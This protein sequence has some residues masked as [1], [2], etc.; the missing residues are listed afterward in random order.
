MRVS[1]VALVATLVLSFLGT[2]TAC[3]LVPSQASCDFRPT[4]ALC[5]DLLTNRNGQL[6]PTLVTLCVGAYSDALCNRA[7][8]LGGCEC[9]SC[10]NGKSITWFY[11]DAATKI[12]TAA[13]VMTACKGR[14]FVTP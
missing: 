11:P 7:G 13:D 5:T 9:D 14:P 10:E 6:R 4:T 12:T 1:V 8:S 3:S 2:F